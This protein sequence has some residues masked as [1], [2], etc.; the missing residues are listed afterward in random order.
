MSEGKQINSYY[1]FIYLLKNFFGLS[2]AILDAAYNNTLVKSVLPDWVENQQ[3]RC[4]ISAVAQF[5]R[6]LLRAFLGY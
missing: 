4:L 5:F 6:L 2:I 3:L 1:H